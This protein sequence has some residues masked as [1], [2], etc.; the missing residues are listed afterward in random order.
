MAAYGEVLMA[1]V[2]CLCDRERRC[3]MLSSHPRR[4]VDPLQ[5]TVTFPCPV[6]SSSSLGDSKSQV[7]DLTGCR[8]VERLEEGSHPGSAEQANPVGE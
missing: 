3:S 1:A 6:T 4:G 8:H 5:A 7:H 2:R